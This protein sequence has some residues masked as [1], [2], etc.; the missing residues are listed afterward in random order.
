MEPPAFS[1]V[2]HT[3]FVLPSLPG[4]KSALHYYNS[5]PQGLPCIFLSLLLVCHNPSLPPGHWCA[6]KGDLPGPLRPQVG[7]WGCPNLF[8]LRVSW[9]IISLP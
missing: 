2:P 1:T 3:H 8:T 7:V 4:L 5:L 9:S 6:G